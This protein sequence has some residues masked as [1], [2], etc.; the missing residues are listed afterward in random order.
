MF[1]RFVGRQMSRGPVLGLTQNGTED[2]PGERIVPVGPL[3]SRP[4]DASSAVLAARCS[5]R[6]IEGMGS[7]GKP[8]AEGRHTPTPNGSPGQNLLFQTPRPLDT[9][10]MSAPAATRLTD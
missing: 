1:F 2:S 6:L 9:A 8:V 7:L 4:R 10:R 5:V 3:A